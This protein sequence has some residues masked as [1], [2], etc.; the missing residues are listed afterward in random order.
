M[1]DA[2][3]DK[4]SRRHAHLI[5]I[6]GAGMR[7]LAEVLAQ[8]GWRL[9]GSDAAIHCDD[10]LA[11][12]GVR[13]FDGHSALNVCSDVELVIHSSAIPD[14]NPEL[15]R[16]AE[17]GIPIV[18]YAEMLGLL[19]QGGRGLAIAGTHGKSTTTAM[20]AKIFT[21]AGC[22]PTYVYGAVPCNGTRGGARGQWQ[23]CSR[24]GV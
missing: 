11:A 2:D 4:S 3:L 21:A 18:S 17:L 13:V 10:P 22:D 7:S 15:A 8:K 24:R 20:A 16:A 1:F 9:S 6:G 5:G 14:E 12:A 23:H 19:M